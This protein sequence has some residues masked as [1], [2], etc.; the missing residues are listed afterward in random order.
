MSTLS[1]SDSPL[2]APTSNWLAGRIVV[3]ID[4]STGSFSALRHARRLA[5][6]TGARLEL[7]T[8][9]TYPVKF[10]PMWAPL[11]WSPEEDARTMLR[12]AAAHEFGKEVPATLTSRTY[13][14]SAAGVLIHE[15]AGADLLVVGSRGHGGFAG[16]LLGSVSSACAEH[17]HCPV[18][19][20]PTGSRPGA[21]A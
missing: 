20:I 16:L 18:L 6:L 21:M 15:S 19:V 1:A 13:E 12:E 4:G 8:A 3:G 5:D 14:G 9:W 10:G 7:V 17:A 2:V 11:E